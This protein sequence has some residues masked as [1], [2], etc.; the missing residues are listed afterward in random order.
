ML[1]YPV[2]ALHWLGYRSWKT[3]TATV[4][5]FQDDPS[6]AA[7]QGG[8]RAPV[9]RFR[10]EG[11]DWIEVTDPVFAKSTLRV[12]QTVRVVYPPSSPSQ[13]RLAVNLYTVQLS[14]GTLGLII[15]LVGVFGSG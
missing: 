13:G 8:L 2:A 3:T 1:A 7:D 11:G 15:L 4:V 14:A 6:A 9:L 5:R 12:G 10:P